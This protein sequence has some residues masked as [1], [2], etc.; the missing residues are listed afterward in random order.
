MWVTRWDPGDLARRQGLAAMLVLDH[1][2]AALQAV[3]LAAGM[4]VGGRAAGCAVDAQGEE[5]DGQGFRK[6]LAE[7]RR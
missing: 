5:R 4:A 7:K 1:Q 6:H 3:E 2:K